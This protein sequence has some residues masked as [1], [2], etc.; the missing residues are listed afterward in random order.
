M[1]EKIYKVKIT[2]HI[3]LENHTEYYLT[4]ES[5][6]TTFI[7]QERYSNLKKLADTMKI[8]A[9]NNALF[10]KFPPKKFFGGEDAKFIKKRETEINAFFESI[11]ENPDFL[12]LPSFIKFLEEKKKNYNNRIKENRIQVKFEEK[13]SKSL[14]ESTGEKEPK[15]IS[16]KEKK[17][18]EEFANIVNETK[19]LFYDVNIIYDK[20][21]ISE[22]DA[23][24]KFFKNNK[25]LNSSNENLS[26][27]NDNNFGLIGKNDEEVSSIVKNNKNKIEEMLNI[28]KS[29][30]DKLDTKGIVVPI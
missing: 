3:K 30:N 10:P 5:G 17:E 18:D 8:E 28:W 22:N 29:L 12:K 13:N 6:S 21:M 14:I 9:K 2:G 16:G 24:V 15:I 25:I 23:F 7:I 20:E 4:I 1:E 19:L 26:A 11:N 27:K